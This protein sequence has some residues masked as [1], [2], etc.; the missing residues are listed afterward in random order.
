[1][2]T[3]IVALSFTLMQLYHKHFIICWD[4]A[5]DINTIYI[6]LI[7]KDHAKKSITLQIYAG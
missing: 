1:M 7:Y 5:L 6:Q 3:I 4:I 2:Y